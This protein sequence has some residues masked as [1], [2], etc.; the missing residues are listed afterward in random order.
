[1]DPKIDV[2]A[3]ADAVMAGC[4][5]NYDDDFPDDES[6]LAK[7]I[8][9]VHSVLARDE[10][11][12]NLNVEPL[13]DPD[14]LRMCGLNIGI[15]DPETG[16]VFQQA[17]P[18]RDIVPGIEGTSGRERAK[19]IAWGLA[20]WHAEVSHS[21]LQVGDPEPSEPA[22]DPGQATDYVM[23]FCG[24]GQFPDDP[25]DLPRQVEAVRR[26][27]YDDHRNPA[28]EVEPI[29]NTD[30]LFLEQVQVGFVEKRTG[31]V[32]ARPYDLDEI[33]PGIKGT[34]GK[35]RAQIITEG[36]LSRHREIVDAWTAARS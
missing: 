15:R 13:I 7:Q 5:I 36:L 19:V 4:D 23:A 18:M 10:W 26:A 34:T 3:A 8:W 30:E 33:M 1:M 11:L 14:S 9:D 29:L 27:I 16:L 17:I 31:S 22:V 2:D 24:A 28:V 25:A 32:V 21:L 6:M 35:A 20:T 12:T